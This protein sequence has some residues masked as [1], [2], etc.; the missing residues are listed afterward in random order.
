MN[1]CTCVVVYENEALRYSK[2]PVFFLACLSRVCVCVRVSSKTGY[3]C[4]EQVYYTVHTVIPY[5]YL[6]CTSRYLTLSPNYK[7]I[8]ILIVETHFVWCASRNK[9][10]RCHFERP[11]CCNRREDTRLIVCSR[12]YGLV[13]LR[14]IVAAPNAIS[15]NTVTLKV[16]TPNKKV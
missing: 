11:V 12:A 3:T 7:N 14:R 1:Y 9:S 10:I 13:L 8:K 16:V 15:P 5:M 4:I 2:A 6:T